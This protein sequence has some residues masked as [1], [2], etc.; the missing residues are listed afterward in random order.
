MTFHI[1]DLL[2]QNFEV[3]AFPGESIGNLQYLNG[4]SICHIVMIS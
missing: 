4:I 2:K 3:F 1:I